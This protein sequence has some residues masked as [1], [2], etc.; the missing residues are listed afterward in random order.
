MN[1]KEALKKATTELNE[2]NIESA[3]L[4][5]RMLIEYVLYKPRQYIVANDME[6]LTIEQKNRYFELVEKLKMNIPLEHIINKKEFMGL[7]FFV[8]ENVLIPRQDTEVLVE[9]VIN[10]VNK[11]DLN[12]EDKST[13]LQKIKIL[14]LCT[15]SGA[16]AISLAK[17]IENALVVA[18]DISERALEVAI[19]N[20]KENN[21]EVIFIKSDLFEKFEKDE[22]SA[23][24]KFD[25][26]VSNPPYIKK[27]VIEKLDEQV[28]KEPIIAL[29]GGAEGLDF[30]KKIVK[31]AHKYLNENGFLCLEIG[32]D[33]KEEV[34]NLIK[35]E[36]I[37]KDIYCIK[38]LNGNDRV[39]VAKK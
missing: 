18:T 38:D 35:N 37:Y 36:K 33:Q 34:T 16:I 31:E 13:C 6:E 26:I 8:N 5:A 3:N 25:V 32:Y 23:K 24:D 39:I 17:Y 15:G 7:N 11:L 4:K 28:K 10:I 29:D 12:K 20:A 27:E 21:M 9:E 19:R 22:T 2:K 14:D 30:Y 1:I